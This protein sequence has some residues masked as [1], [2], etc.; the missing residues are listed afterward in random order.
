MDLA[1]L[2]R[3]LDARVLVA[4]REPGRMFARVYAGDRMSD[5]LAHADD[6]T[7][8]VTH[9]NGP[10]LVRLFDLMEVAGVCVV[11][12][13]DPDDA[14]LVAARDAGAAMLSVR[15]ELYETCGIIHG[16]LA[17]RETAPP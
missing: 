5:L 1:S 14:L 7:L 6:T 3:L 16:A 12:D 9:L 17:G 2:A 10:G 15:H 8:L 11:A 13:I 4:P